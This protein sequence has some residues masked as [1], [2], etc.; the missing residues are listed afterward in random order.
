MSFKGTEYK[1]RIKTV[2]EHDRQGRETFPTMVMG[3]AE[4]AAETRTLV[5]SEIRDGKHYTSL[6]FPPQYQPVTGRECALHIQ[7]VSYLC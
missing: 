1:C 6:I 3:S 7:K 4:G 2:S 5:R